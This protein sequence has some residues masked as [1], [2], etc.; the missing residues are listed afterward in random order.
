MIPIN[1]YTRNT[2]LGCKARVQRATRKKPSA[3]LRRLSAVTDCCCLRLNYVYVTGSIRKFYSDT[4]HCCGVGR[5][6]FTIKTC[7]PRICRYTRTQELR[8]GGLSPR[9]EQLFWSVWHPPIP[10]HHL[11][12]M[13]SFLFLLH[14][15]RTQRW[16]REIYS[17]DLTQVYE[18]SSWIIISDL[19]RTTELRHAPLDWT[20]TTKRL[21]V[22]ISQVQWSRGGRG[23]RQFARTNRIIRGH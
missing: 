17:T 11:P 15:T 20:K 6:V 4:A 23:A 10:L 2:C 12:T 19:C 21:G 5:R 8:Y 3:N 18:A 7:F 16:S 13:R 1:L 22:E 14:N 9:H